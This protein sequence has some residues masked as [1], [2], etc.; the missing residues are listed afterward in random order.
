MAAGYV[1]FSRLTVNK[2]D[3]IDVETVIMQSDQC[4]VEVLVPAA[5]GALED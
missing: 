3:G 4:N 5:V 1:L 2:S